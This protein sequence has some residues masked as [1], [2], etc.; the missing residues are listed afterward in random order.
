MD[1]V[2]SLMCGQNTTV[3]GDTPLVVSMDRETFNTGQNFS[4]TLGIHEDGIQPTLVTRGP[5]GVCYRDQS[6]QSDMT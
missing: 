6:T 5:G 3:R 2:G 1:A 4:K